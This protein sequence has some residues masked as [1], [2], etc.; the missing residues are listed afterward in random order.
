[1]SVRTPLLVVLL[2][3]VAAPA[4]AGA[5]PAAT[6]TPR[7]RVVRPDPPRFSAETAAAIN[8]GLAKVNADLK[9]GQA[10]DVEAS[11]SAVSRARSA[12]LTPAALRRSQLLAEVRQI[13]ESLKTASPAEREALG[14]RLAAMLG[15]ARVGPK[16]PNVRPE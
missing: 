4:A 11:L 6:P 5:P 12:A 8:D 13:R 15:E 16:V 2:T 1:M 3:A 14:R 7:P 9:K 10:H